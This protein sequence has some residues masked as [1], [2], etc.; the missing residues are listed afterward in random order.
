MPMGATCE[1]HTEPDSKSV[2][3]RYAERFLYI[4]I[5]IK[6][7]LARRLLNTH[8]EIVADNGNMQG[9]LEHNAQSGHSRLDVLHDQRPSTGS[10]Q[11]T[12][13]SPDTGHGVQDKKKPTPQSFGFRPV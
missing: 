13:L 11:P 8:R 7:H 3:D 9:W 6:M 5:Y 10:F 1:T 12:L 2:A 4:P